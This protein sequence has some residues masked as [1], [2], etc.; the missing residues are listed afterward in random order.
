MSAPI[1]EP[2]AQINVRVWDLPTR[3]FHWLIVVLFAISWWTAENDQLDWHMLSGYGILA[4]LFFRIYWGFAG[5]QTARFGN[6]LKGPRAF[7]AYSA[8]MFERPERPTPGHNPMGGWSVAAFISLLLLQTVLGLFAIDVDGLNA[9][10]LDHLVSF[11]TGRRAAGLHDT[12]F[13]FLLILIGLHTAAVLFYWFYKRENLIAAMV[14]GLKR[15][16]RSIEPDLHF[17]SLWW[18]VPGLLVAGLIVAWLALG[19]F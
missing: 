12:V 19:Y 13:N 17:T 8:R 1:E 16:P 15:M 6:F 5:S 18:A 7:L 9:G 14:T 11:E 10:P 3:L 2:V 4:L